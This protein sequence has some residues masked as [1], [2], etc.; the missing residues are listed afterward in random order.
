MTIQHTPGPWLIAGETT[1]Y[2]LQHAGYRKGEEQFE[3]RFSASVQGAHT[4]HAEHVATAR[5]IAAAP[6]L[7]RELQS[8][9]G[10]FSG[11]QGMQLRDAKAA[12]AKATGEPVA[13]GGHTE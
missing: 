2:A 8:M 5:L 11:Y 6:D 13:E 7:L 9:V 1:V 4:P 10:F 12:I 3:N